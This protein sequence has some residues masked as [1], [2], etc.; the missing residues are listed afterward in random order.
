MRRSITAGMSTPR[1]TAHGRAH[2]NTAEGYFSQLKRSIDGTHHH[3]SAKHLH[4]YVGEFDYRYNTRKV[5][6]GE[7]TV[8]AI[9]QSAGKR[10]MYEESVRKVAVP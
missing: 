8:R 9:R 5:K 6:D 10:L 7:R 3:V 4:R 1:T 2:I